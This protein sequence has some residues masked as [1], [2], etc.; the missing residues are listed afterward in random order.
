MTTCELCASD[1]GLLVFRNEQLRIVQV[2]DAVG[3][4]GFYRVIWNQHVAEFSDLT[5]AER[6]VCMDVVLRVEQVLRSELRPTKINIASLGNMT[7]HLHWHVMAR[8]DWDTHFPAPIWAQ[9]ARALD[10]GQVARVQAQ[11]PRINQLIVQA[12]A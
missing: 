10:E 2:Q 7:P 8:F 12:Q 3:F 11:C 1:G 5:P 9:P 6:S 4:P